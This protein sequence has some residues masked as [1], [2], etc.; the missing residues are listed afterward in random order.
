VIIYPVLMDGTFYDESHYK[1]QDTR[2][3]ERE[4]KRALATLERLGYHVAVSPVAEAAKVPST[5]G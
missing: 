4:K 5:A 1:R 2:Q 3:E